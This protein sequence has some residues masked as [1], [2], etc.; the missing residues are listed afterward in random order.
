M[1]EEKRQKTIDVMLI[2]KSILATSRLKSMLS[3]YIECS[4]LNFS[5]FQNAVLSLSDRTP[6]LIITE[7]ELNG[8]SAID[9]MNVLSSRQDWNDIPVLV[10]TDNPTDEL[11]NRAES[12]GVVDV[13]RKPVKQTD[14]NR[15]LDQIFSDIKKSREET[16]KLP[17]IRSQ[18][19][20][21][22]KLAPL[23]TLMKSI[24]EL[25]E[26]PKTSASKLADVI[27]TD[28]SLTA[29]ILKIVNS[30][31]YGFHRE[32]GNIN[33]AVVILGFNEIK[34]IT[35][36]ACLI[37]YFPNGGD[38]HFNRNEFW[39]HALGAAYTAS[40]LSVYS[41]KVIANDA[42]VIGL[43]HDFGKVVLDQHFKES[44]R[45]VIEKAVQEKRPLHEVSVELIG[46]DHT[47]IG[48]LVAESWNLPVP[49]VRAIEYHHNPSLVNRQDHEVHIAHLANYFC[50]KHQIGSSGNPL[51]DEPNADSLE[52]LGF[53][54][55]DLDHIWD[56]L[57]L[58]TDR[59]RK[60]N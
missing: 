43:L 9:L 36:A 37:Q 16:K 52:A 6:E 56:S 32:I 59:L 1:T 31:Y 29:K 18:L 42:F 33:H 35:L 4:V 60:L 41:P 48:G 51:P 26:N 28:M 34:N 49:L 12:E 17:D 14:L 19:K 38:K 40:A 50:H 27:K 45:M 22:D 2:D 57:K 3:N 8:Y 21:I 54:V 30:A 55:T 39:I 23:P 13:L 10:S 7:W 25:S 47:E 15:S 46:I 53:N 24:L 11:I 58:D 44:F 20:R 5:S